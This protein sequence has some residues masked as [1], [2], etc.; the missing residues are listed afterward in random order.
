M[1][2]PDD[3]LR[4]PHVT[5]R[6]LEIAAPSSDPLRGPSQGLMEV[7]IDKPGALPLRALVSEGAL[8]PDVMRELSA[9]V[10]ELPRLATGPGEGAVDIR[11]ESRDGAHVK[12]GVVVLHGAGRELDAPIDPTSRR[13]RLG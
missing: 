7:L 11:L 10:G 4:L 2:K 5:F 12:S 13:F 8:T 9:R 1:I 3:P 6:P